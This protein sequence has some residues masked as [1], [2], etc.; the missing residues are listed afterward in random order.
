VAADPG[1]GGTA[2]RDTRRHAAGVGRRPSGHSRAEG[3]SRE[4]R[5]VSYQIVK[6][7]IR[8][9]IW[10]SFVQNGKRTAG[11]VRSAFPVSGSRRRF[12]HARAAIRSCNSLGPPRLAAADCKVYIPVVTAARVSLSSGS[13]ADQTAPD[14]GGSWR[15]RRVVESGAAP[16]SASGER[17]GCSSS[18]RGS[19][20]PAPQPR[21][22]APGAPPGHPRPPAMP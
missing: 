13:R 10:N 6:H 5:R 22:A 11:R 20:V 18:K 7:L 21:A 14:G 15:A 19:A 17:P 16:P 12:V 9:Q 4:A 2:G 1:R 8:Q 3:W